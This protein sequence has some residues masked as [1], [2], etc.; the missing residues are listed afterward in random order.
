MMVKVHLLR[1]QDRAGD[2][3]G[4]GGTARIPRT[5]IPPP[6]P[7]ARAD[8]RQYSPIPEAALAATA[9]QAVL[10]EEEEEATDLRVYPGALCL[11]RRDAEHA[12]LSTE[13]CLKVV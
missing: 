10:R 12:S 1:I 7:D 3:H 5:A 6:R 13:S 2:G 11:S 4:R 8:D 9:L